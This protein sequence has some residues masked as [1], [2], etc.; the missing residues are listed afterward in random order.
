MTLKEEKCRLSVLV[1]ALNFVIYASLKDDGHIDF[2]DV[3]VSK[4]RLSDYNFNLRLVLYRMG[5]VK[6][7]S[8]LSMVLFKP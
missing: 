5:N 2:T 3:I 6:A 4:K 7:Y 8:S 1:V